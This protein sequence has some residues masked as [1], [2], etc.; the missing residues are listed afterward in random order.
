MHR[1]GIPQEG[2]LVKAQNTHLVRLYLLS[3]QLGEAGLH[4]GLN[5]GGM[6]V[7]LATWTECVEYDIYVSSP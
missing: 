6:D 1:A 2:Q 3:V 4:C 7:G 5:I